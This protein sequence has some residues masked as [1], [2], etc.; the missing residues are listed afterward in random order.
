MA[1]FDFIIKFDPEKESITD[2]GQQIIISLIVNKLKQKKPVRIF[3]GGDSSEGKSY[4]ALKLQYIILKHYGLDYKDYI[5]DMNIY[6]PLEYPTKIDALLNDERLRN[7]NVVTLHEAR[8][9]IPAK[10]W[11]DF[12]TQAVAFVNAT[13]RAIKP[14]CTIIVSQFIRDVTVD[15]R[16]TLNYYCICKRPSHQRARFYINVI[17]KDDYDLDHPRIAKRK[18][19]GLLIDPKGRHTIYR[20]DY[21]EVERPEKE[22]CEAFDKADYDAKKGMIDNKLK[23]LM[24]RLKME[25][26]QESAKVTA[27][28]EWYSNNMDRLS[29]I[30][31][32]TKKGFVV[33]R[34][35]IRM[36]D[37]NND[38][39]KEF[40]KKLNTV[41]K[42]KG[43]VVDGLESEQT[44]EATG[45]TI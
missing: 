13:S 20:P 11:Q 2:L 24:E 31:K 10:M 9:V 38:Q 18:L 32:Q 5:N 40:Q 34:D 19:R 14:T 8:E 21:L 36:H 15:I 3:I 39:Y 37:L 45:S 7:I 26:G 35:V 29:W 16:Y 42:N 44:T 43:V 41:L 1:H 30:G 4:T 6:T 22:V 23:K 25:Y 12:V 33:S 17:Y 28:V 27:M